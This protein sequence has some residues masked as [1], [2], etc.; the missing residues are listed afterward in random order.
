[1]TLWPTIM[2]VLT[3]SFLSLALLLSNG[4]GYRLLGWLNLTIMALGI[5]TIYMDH[6]ETVKRIVNLNEL[7]RL[8]K[9]KY[10]GKQ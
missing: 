4:E 3:S 1:M 5:L 8:L 2:I 10:K 7:K 9:L 6:V